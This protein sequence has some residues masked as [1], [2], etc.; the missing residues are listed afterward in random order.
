MSLQQLIHLYQSLT[1]DAQRE[2]IHF[3]QFM[4]QKEKEANQ[5]PAK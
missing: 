1:P 2:A 5:S 3:M 4:Q